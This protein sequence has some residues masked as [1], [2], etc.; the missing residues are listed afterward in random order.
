MMNAIRP[1][2]GVCKLVDSLPFKLP[3]NFK[4]AIWDI[5]SFAVEEQTS[6]TVMG[7]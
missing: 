3:A 6:S 1:E 4:S 2:I 5:R 7:V